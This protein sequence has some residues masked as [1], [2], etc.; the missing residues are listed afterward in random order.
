M[1]LARPFAFAQLRNLSNMSLRPSP[2]CLRKDGL[3]HVH[4]TDVMSAMRQK[5]I[6]RP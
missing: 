4:K 2:Y 3:R 6:Y 1:C 5:R